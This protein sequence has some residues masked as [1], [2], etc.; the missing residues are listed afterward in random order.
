MRM[1][2]SATRGWLASICAR[3][4]WPSA[5]RP[6]ISTPLRSSVSAIAVNIAGWS[7]AITHVIRSLT[8][9]HPF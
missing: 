3:A 1:S 6:T 2:T 9:A 5:A 4:S 7:S 8:Q